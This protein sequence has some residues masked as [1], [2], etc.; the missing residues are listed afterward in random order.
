MAWEGEEPGIV[1]GV[2][3]KKGP[4]EGEEPDGGADAIQLFKG[5][6]AAGA[7]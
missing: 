3:A 6:A 1:G 4:E 7:L 2:P 5:G